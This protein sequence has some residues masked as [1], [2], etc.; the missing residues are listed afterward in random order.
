M[1]NEEEYHIPED[2]QPSAEQIPTDRPAPAPA[3]AS[4][5]TKPKINLK[6]LL[7]IVVAIAVIWAGHKMFSAFM[8][9]RKPKSQNITKLSNMPPTPI[10]QPQAFAPVSALPA[11]TPALGAPAMSGVDSRLAAIEEGNAEAQAKIERANAN[12][13]EL[14]N[15]IAT[16][17]SQMSTLNNAIQDL[18]AQVTQQQAQIQALMTG[19]GA[20]K[21]NKRARQQQRVARK[22]Y[23]IQALIPGRAWLTSS[24]DRMITVREGDTVPGY[25]VVTAIDP[26]QSAVMTSSGEIIVFKGE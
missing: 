4:T 5:S 1:A 11:K 9:A 2:E 22:Q 19:G 23:Y 26:A 21:R 15:M 7:I 24:D 6:R 18:T 16:M 3:A 8:S 10:A 12:M 17:T 20:A 14:Q 13:A 25:G